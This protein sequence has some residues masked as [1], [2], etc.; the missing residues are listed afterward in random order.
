[1]RAT[2]MLTSGPAIDSEWS[3]S[4][5]GDTPRRALSK[6]ADQPQMRDP[7]MKRLLDGGHAKMEIHIR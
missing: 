5:T 6:L 7:R 2:A 1:M 3:C 4:T